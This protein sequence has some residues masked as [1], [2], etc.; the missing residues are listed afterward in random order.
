LTA[1]PEDQNC[2]DDLRCA[3]ANEQL[4][5]PASSGVAERE[6]ASSE[7]AR[8]CLGPLWRGSLHRRAC[9]CSQTTSVFEAEQAAESLRNFCSELELTIMT[10]LTA[11]TPAPI[12]DDKA[13]IKLSSFNAPRPAGPLTSLRRWFSVPNANPCWWPKQHDRESGQF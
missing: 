2:P 5:Q 10:I 12:S 1:K 9:R 6:K 8:V 4:L 11:L 7:P 3:A 13:A